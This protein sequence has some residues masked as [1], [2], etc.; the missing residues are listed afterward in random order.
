MSKLPVGWAQVTFKDVV[1]VNPRKSTDLKFD[2]LVT[3]V[4]MAAVSEISGEIIEGSSRP[5]QE[6]SR[7]FTQFSENDV[8]FAKITP[9]MENGKAAIARGLENGVGFG[10]TEF[11][12]LRSYGAVMPE[13]LWRFMRQ[14]SFRESARKVMSGAVGQ[15]R[16]PAD[17]LKEHS[18]PLP[19]LAEQERIVDSLNNF[20]T[21]VAR[22]QEEINHIPLLIEKYKA[23]F[24]ANVYSGKGHFSSY[25][26]NDDFCTLESVCISLTDGDHQAPPRSDEGIPFITISNMNRGSIKL[27]QAT[28]FVPQQYYD[29]LSVARKA[30]KGDV[31]FSVTGTIGIPALVRDSAPFVFQR[32]IAILKPKSEIILSEYLFYILSAPQVMEQVMSVATGSAQLTIPLRG[33]R[34]FKIPV[35]S[36]PEQLRIVEQFNKIFT[37]LDNISAEYHA[38]LN[39]LPKLESEILSKAF[40]GRLVSQ[41]D[42]DEAASKLIERIQSERMHKKKQPLPRIRPDKRPVKRIKM[43]E[44]LYDVLLGA[45]DWLPAQEI[46]RRCGVVDGTQTERIEELYAELRRLDK[47]GLLQAQPVNNEQ[48]R[49][50]Y[51]LLRIIEK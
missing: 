22:A 48:G 24:L 47:A 31:L 4:P 2:D 16:V 36:L 25:A 1:E 34:L 37:W 18:L 50:L 9:S 8:I 10:S 11:H 40:K 12:V 20:I 7:G 43:E 49:K 44:N 33:L 41:I 27:E 21:R 23:Q 45:E 3:F 15:Q 29:G 28:R 14:R 30:K 17:Y 6:V 39:L 26:I 46:F 5:L 35:P 19:P 13:Y 38:A 42:S 51:D 32:H